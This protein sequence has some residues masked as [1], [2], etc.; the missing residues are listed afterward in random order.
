[1]NLIVILSGQ[2]IQQKSFEAKTRE[3]Y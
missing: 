3:S 1:M 2:F